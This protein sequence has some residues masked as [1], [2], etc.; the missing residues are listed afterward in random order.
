MT[1]FT[2]TMPQKREW[3]AIAKALRKFNHHNDKEILDELKVFHFTGHFSDSELEAFFMDTN[4]LRRVMLSPDQSDD[5]YHHWI[6]RR[7]ARSRANSFSDFPKFCEI[8]YSVSNIEVC[9]GRTEKIAQMFVE[10]VDEEPGFWQGLKSWDYLVVVGKWL[11]SGGYQQSPMIP[12]FPYACKSAIAYCDREGWGTRLKSYSWEQLSPIFNFIDPEGLE[13]EQSP[14]YALAAYAQNYICHEMTLSPPFKQ[15]LE[16]KL[17]IDDL[18]QFQCLPLLPR[19]HYEVPEPVKAFVIK[20][21]ER[22]KA[23][24][25][26]EEVYLEVYDESNEDCPHPPLRFIAT[27]QQ[28]L[29]QTINGIM[30]CF[31]KQGYLKRKPALKTGEIGLL[32][33]DEFIT[34]S[35]SK[36]QLTARYYRFKPHRKLAMSDELAL[37]ITL[38]LSKEPKPVAGGE[39]IDDNGAH[40]LVIHQEQWNLLIYIDQPNREII[41]DASSLMK[42]VLQLIKEINTKLN[43]QFTQSVPAD[44]LDEWN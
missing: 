25:R 28:E 26:E 10:G 36:E 38:A 12:V 41:E 14:Y 27:T 9:P 32:L 39:Y 24:K 42:N 21:L 37:E 23:V 30:A 4:I 5:Y 11:S 20:G 40:E 15:L 3:K 2:L 29:V 31:K 35:L 44:V 1:E 34:P 43:L 17:V 7:K 13:P 18:A 33:S 19:P 22:E 16:E 6:N 8:F